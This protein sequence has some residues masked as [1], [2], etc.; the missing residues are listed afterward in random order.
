MESDKG[1]TQRDNEAMRQHLRQYHGAASI[2][3]WHFGQA[4]FPPTYTDATRP[5]ASSVSAGAVIYNSTDNGLNVSD[6]SDWRAPNGGWAV[7]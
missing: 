5:S 7:T 3:S 4:V 6:G 1:I 2:K